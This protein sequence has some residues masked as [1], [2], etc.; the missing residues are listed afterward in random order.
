MISS[1]ISNFAEK[2]KNIVHYIVVFLMLAL[3]ACSKSCPDFTVQCSFTD[4]KTDSITLFVLEDDYGMMRMAGGVAVLDGK[5]QLRGQLDAPVIAMLKI[6]KVD[7]PFYF[8]LEPG[9]TTIQFERGCTL[10]W[11]GEI[12]HMYADF[13]QRREQLLQQRVANRKQ[14]MKLVADSSLTQVQE[15]C[16]MKTDSVLCDSVQRITVNIING[17]DLVGKLVSQQ[18]AA[19]LDSLHRTKL[20]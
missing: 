2:M 3:C 10:V 4:V 20:Q 5:A 17:G 15:L 1:I 19:T 9:V 16:M 8:I 18:Y 11:G 13:E 6:N 12:N 14:Y 7:A